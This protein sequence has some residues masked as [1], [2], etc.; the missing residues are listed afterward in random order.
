MH[1]NTAFPH[2]CS[3][4]SAILFMVWNNDCVK[5]GGGDRPF[6]VRVLVSNQ[7]VCTQ[8]VVSSSGLQSSRERLHALAVD[9]ALR[10]GIVCNTSV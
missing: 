9:L 10:Y 3:I 7:G 4:A 6:I 2:S 8:V 5:M 1:S